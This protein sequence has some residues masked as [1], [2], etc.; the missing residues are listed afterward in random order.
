MKI[1]QVKNK[2]ILKSILGIF[3]NKE[4][5]RK[6]LMEIADYEDINGHPEM[7]NINHIQTNVRR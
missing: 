5:K 1:E 4:Y 3:W 7:L 6:L 2:L